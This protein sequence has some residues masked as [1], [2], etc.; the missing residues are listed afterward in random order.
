[1]KAYKSLVLVHAWAASMSSE[2]VDMYLPA[3]NFMSHLA[4]LVAAHSVHAFQ[5]L[6]SKDNSEDDMWTWESSVS[7][8]LRQR[9]YTEDA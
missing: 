8:T 7:E 3:S 5:V 4:V 2:R 9:S 6:L 1:M